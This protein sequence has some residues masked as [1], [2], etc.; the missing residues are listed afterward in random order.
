MKGIVNP[1]K[2]N[3][4]LD[5]SQH[6]PC[7]EQIKKIWHCDVCKINKNANSKHPN[8]GSIE[9]ASHRKKVISSEKRPIKVKISKLNSLK[10]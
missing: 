3:C 9:N 7:L 2:L 1:L 6:L 10:N 5:N 4:L 8:L